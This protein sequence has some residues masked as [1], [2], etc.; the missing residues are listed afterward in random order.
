MKALEKLNYS[1]ENYSRKIVGD[2]ATF[3][4]R[5]N[6]PYWLVK[7]FNEAA[8]EVEQPLEMFRS[9]AFITDDK[10]QYSLLS[11]A[12]KNTAYEIIIG[13]YSENRSLDK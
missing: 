12:F 5:R 2:R 13:D 1:I 8:K 9:G 7:L 11:T 10:R 3:Y 6:C 4:Q